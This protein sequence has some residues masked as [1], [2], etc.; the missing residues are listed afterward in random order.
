VKL[1]R[2]SLA[3]LLFC[4]AAPAAAPFDSR[5]LA[6][7]KPF[8]SRAL[9]QGRQD[10]SVRIAA[11]LDAI[12]AGNNSAARR[13]AIVAQL[14]S[15][16][17]DPV[18]EPFGEGRAAGANVVVTLPAPGPT[19]IVIG[20]H[21]DRVGVGRGAV[22]NGGSC[23]VLIELI[24]A[25]KASPL[26]RSTLR[27]VF[28]DREEVGLVGSRMHFSRPGHR[29]DYAINLDV[30]AYGDTIFAT[31]SRPDG[32][33]LRSLRAAGEATGLPVRDVPPSRYPG[34][35]HQTMINAQIETLGLALV[36]KADVDGL[37]AVDPSK[38]AAGDGRG[39]R[40]LQIIHSPNDNLSA[41][42]VDQMVRGL[43]LVEQLIRLVDAGV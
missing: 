6:Q 18:V 16:D 32:L 12:V 31:G 1:A 21:L 28:F 11:S 40:V 17:V 42:K 19:T 38:L 15:I 8:D 30:F 25:F 7:G 34:S 9:A 35:D 27:V 26:T 41:V 23:A 43:G 4:L 10:A 39:P 20:A 5:A 22:D 14:K 37:L 29:A 33:L 24:A 2:L 3:C 13:D 36:D